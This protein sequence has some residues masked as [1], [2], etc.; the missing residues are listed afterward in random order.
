MLT[1]TRNLAIWNIPAGASAVQYA[2][3]RTQPSCV[4]LFAVPPQPLNT[5]ALLERLSGLLKF[6]ISH[7]QGQFTL[8]DL[9]GACAQTDETVQVGLDWLAARGYFTFQQQDDY[10]WRVQPGDRQAAPNLKALAAKLQRQLDESAPY[11]EY[12]TRAKPENL[13]QCE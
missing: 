9:A 8:A 13:L 2:L 10:L 11:R 3:K 12:Y 4:Y 1:S 5:R 7:R 6:A